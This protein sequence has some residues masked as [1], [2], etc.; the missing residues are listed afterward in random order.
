MTTKPCH[1]SGDAM[2]VR[3]L[4]IALDSGRVATL[5]AV[6]FSTAG[7]AWLQRTFSSG[8]PTSAPAD[9]RTTVVGVAR[10]TR[11]GAAVDRPSGYFVIA[12]LKTWPRNMLG[13]TIRARGT[14]VVEERTILP[15]SEEYPAETEMV[16]ELRGATWELLP[17]TR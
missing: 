15:P 9:S 12:G 7:C 5:L 6:V 8:A 2:V 1:E 11:F 13:K 16:M 10:N 14:K 17:D 4:R 3:A